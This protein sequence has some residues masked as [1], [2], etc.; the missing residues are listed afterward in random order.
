MNT[1][2]NVLTSIRKINFTKESKKSAK[3]QEASIVEFKRTI[4][5]QVFDM[6][7]E[8]SAFEAKNIMIQ[9]LN[10]R[11]AE[12]VKMRNEKK[13]FSKRDQSKNYLHNIVLTIKDEIMELYDGIEVE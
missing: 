1:L 5:E 3:I 9:S 6:S 2:N 10:I 11:M 12:I 4:E 8:M 7:K 13:L